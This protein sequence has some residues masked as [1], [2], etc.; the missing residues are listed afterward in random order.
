MSVSRP[1]VNRGVSHYVSCDQGTSHNFSIHYKDSVAFIR[2][3][4]FY[5]TC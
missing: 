3:M 1:Q 5:D 4:L 2:G